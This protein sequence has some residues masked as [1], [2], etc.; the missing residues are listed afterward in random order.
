VAGSRACRNAGRLALLPLRTA[1]RAPLVAPAL[2]RAAAGLAA[3][4]RVARADGRRR[5]DDLTDSVL[6]A[7]E[8]EQTVD[9][10][11]AGP[12][13]E[14]IGRSLAENQVPRRIAAEFLAHTRVEPASDAPVTSAALEH[15]A[16][17][18]SLEELVV[19]VIESRLAADVA[20][21]VLR[22]P[23]FEHAV[24]SVASSP[25][26]RAAVAAQTRS[27]VDDVVDDVRTTT[28]R[29]DDSAEC[30]VRRWLP[31]A[32]QEQ[33]AEAPRYGGLATRAV[34]FL[35]DVALADLLALG[36]AA[37][38][39]LA[40]SVVGG[41]RPAWL[42]GALVAVG[43][44]LVVDVYLVLFWTMTG[45]TPGM[46]FMQLRVVGPRGEPPGLGRAVLR[47]V[48]LLLSIALF[49]IGFLP[50]LV[51]RRRR[52]VH[53]MLAGTVVESTGPA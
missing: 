24:E 37:G 28:E 53:D 15:A 5:V 8:V 25:A 42:V 35:I 19:E 2:R 14:A 44:A 18:P 38:V 50:V 51:D 43:W 27:L 34:A 47:L 13:T 21:R 48:G 45:R 36:V 3:D 22:S 33:R 30:T 32:R 17:R 10:A 40:A 20:D 23:E 6:A 12:L 11:L 39:Y 4:G 16:V 9:R 26:V 41:L 46:R 1:S 7:P 52:G 29:L 49:F 31:G